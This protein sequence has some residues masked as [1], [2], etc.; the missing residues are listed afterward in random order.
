MSKRQP[1]V[2][3]EPSAEAPKYW[4][5]LEERAELSTFATPDLAAKRAAEFPDGHFTTP[6]SDE[7]IALGRRGFLGVAG[8]SLALAGTAGCR[9]PEEKIVPYGKMPEQIVPGVASFYATAIASRGEAL[10]LLVESHEGRPTKVEGN[11]DHPASLGATDIAG[12]AS[13]LEL[14]D[15]DRSQAPSKGGKRESFEPF[16]SALKSKLV[17]ADAN[18]GAKL[19]F[20]AHPTTSPTELRLRAEMQKRYPS[21]K[22]TVFAPL[23]D[24]NV[25]L[26]TKLAFGKALRPLVDYSRTKIIVSLDADFLQVETGAVRATKQFAASRRL[27]TAT[28]TMSRLYVAEAHFSTTGANADHRVRVPR[29]QIAKVASAIAARLGTKH[30][31]ALGEVAQV[32]QGPAKVDGVADAWLDA[33]AKDLADNRGASAVVVGASQP[34]AVHAA[35]AA[36]NAALGNVARTVAYFEPVDAAEGDALADLKALVAE[37]AAGQ[38][39]TLIVLGGNPV[40]DAPA[41]LKFGDA[42]AKVAFSVHLSS[43]LDETGSRTTWHLPRAHAFEA[44][45]DHRGVDGTVA[46]QQPLIQPLYQAWSDI[47]VLSR[48]TSLT[49]RKGYDLA[50]LTARDHFLGMR[51]YTLC[52]SDGVNIQCRDAA[53]ATTVLTTAALEREWKKALYD[54]RIGA[55]RGGVSDLAVTAATVAQALAKVQAPAPSKGSLEALFIPCAKMLDGRFANNPWLLEMPDP[56]THVVWDNPALLAPAT[57]LELGIENGDMLDVTAGGQTVKVVAYVHPGTAANVVVLSS[58][59]GRT[60]AGRLGNGKGFDIGPL[61]TSAGYH[62]ASAA[63]VTKSGTTYQVAQT[64]S[65]HSAEGRPIAREATLSEF[66]ANPNFAQLQSPTPKL[67]PL[68]QPQDYSQGY[69]W[70]MVVD[71][72]SCT[73]CGSCVVACQA[74]NNVPVVGKVEVARGRE[75]HW[76]RIDRYFVED[77]K[78]G[79]TADDPL[80]VAQ[81]LMCVHCETAPC[82]NVCPVN[83]TVHSAEGLNEIA[84]NRCIG[85]R[86]CANNCPYKVRR[87]NYL[88]WHNDSVW[89]KEKDYPE[90]YQMQHNPNV[91]VRFRGVIEKC[92]YCVQRIQAAKIKAKR[93]NRTIVDGEVRSA[94]QQVCP[95][96]AIEFGNLNDPTSRVAKAARNHRNYALLGEI[97]TKPRTTYLGKVRNPNPDLQKALAASVPSDASA[98]GHH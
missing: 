56:N 57:A 21:A 8:A 53:G 65:H 84:Y 39:D 41:D 48:F 13:I 92:S 95:A 85:T 24:G 45:G 36:I 16:E 87:F 94:C 14:Y 52:G 38:V 74:E 72:N 80:V 11:P 68:W 20:L 5:T 42:L 49:E 40:Y 64:Q 79:A 97:G 66:Q 77:P 98:K 35:A 43:H 69:Q 25:L 31:V 78:Q 1:Y 23:S 3:L 67:L 71:L 33:V 9:R 15:I 46:L 22:L 96:D 89:A 29:S 58:G 44:W 76:M 50:R 6:P 28:D 81:P 75:M 18:K 55:T 7:A 59:W 17:A 51:G 63:K 93:E 34:P 10:G 2:F 61:R 19:R 83:A 4:R 37:M 54:G 70:G 30:G 62:F 12:Q 32:T 26:G 88:N 82:E 47:E 60:R 86:Y 73:G 91:T 90:T 27:V